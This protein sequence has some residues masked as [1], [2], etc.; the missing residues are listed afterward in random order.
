MLTLKTARVLLVSLFFLYES[1][2][3]GCAS[4]GQNTRFY[5]LDPVS[6]EI[7]L[8]NMVN[9]GDHLSIEIMSLRL[10]R[11]LERPQIVTRDE[12]NR[13]KLAE[14]HRWGGNLQKNIVR[15]L[16]KNLSFL[17]QTPDVSSYTRNPQSPPDFRIEMAVMKFEK[18]PDERVRLS[19][20]WTLSRGK[21]NSLLTVK[22]T[23]LESSILQPGSDMDK[24]VSAM[25]I[26][27]GDLSRIIG[28]EIIRHR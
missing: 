14:F 22:I 26:L 21:D 13:I 7:P 16:A 20:Q 9:Q 8:V 2:I 24:T 12:E 6:M 4:G 17:L 11:Y 1:M 5:V 25:N 28:K 3:Y 23:D 18:D 10:P 19:A 27:I 15:V